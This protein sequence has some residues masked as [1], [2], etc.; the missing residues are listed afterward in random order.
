MPLD[1]ILPMSESDGEFE[2][3]IKNS[4]SGTA[5]IAA[6]PLASHECTGKA[7]RI[8]EAEGGSSWR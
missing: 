8:L 7:E 3:R 2:Y 5:R 4:V 6:E 1:R